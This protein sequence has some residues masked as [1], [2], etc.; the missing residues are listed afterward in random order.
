MLEGDDALAAPFC[1]RRVGVELLPGCL[2]EVVEVADRELLGGVVDAEVADV[3]D[4]HAEG[5]A[6]VPEVIARNHL[7]AV[8]AKHPRERV[9]DH[10]AAKVPDVQLLADARARVVERDSVALG[11]L[12]HAEPGAEHSNSRTARRRN[13]D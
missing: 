10:G 5:R 6:P 11:C 1:E 2:V 13:R 3:L 7:V 8:E 4:Q 12:G 9:A